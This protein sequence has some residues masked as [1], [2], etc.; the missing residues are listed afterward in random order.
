M[1]RV[2]MY[3]SI[4]MVVGTEGPQMPRLAS[5]REIRQRQN[6]WWPP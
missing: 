2:K 6:T 5:H 4:S 1:D 3:E